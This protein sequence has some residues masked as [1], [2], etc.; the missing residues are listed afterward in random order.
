ML[1]KARKVGYAIT[2][3]CYL[4]KDERRMKEAGNA[5]PS[6]TYVSSLAVWVEG[7]R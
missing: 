2:G 4:N 1:N 3:K 5:I 6:A 7:E